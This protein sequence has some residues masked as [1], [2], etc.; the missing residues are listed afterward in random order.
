MNVE[1]NS[2]NWLMP[3]QGLRGM[4]LDM[5]CSVAMGL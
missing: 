4:N 1:M 5:K 3:H 2:D